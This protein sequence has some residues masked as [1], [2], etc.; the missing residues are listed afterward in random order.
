MLKRKKAI[1]IVE[2]KLSLMRG[3]E[4]SLNDLTTKHTFPTP[5][6]FEPLESTFEVEVSSTGGNVYVFDECVENVEAYEEKLEEF[7]T[8][9]DNSDCHLIKRT[10]VT[11]Y[12]TSNNTVCLNS[13]GHW[14]Q[15]NKVMV[16]LFILLSLMI[17]YLGLNF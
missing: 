13:L 9:T 4:E 1:G 16:S 3:F 8:K 12:L 6:C 10:S 5:I 7:K 17:D 14:I 2:R 15:I 11:I